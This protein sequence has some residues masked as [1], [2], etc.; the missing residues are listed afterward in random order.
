MRGGDDGMTAEEFMTSKLQSI[1]DKFADTVFCP[2]KGLF[3][4]GRE[5]KK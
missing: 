3:E 4:K 1:A 5:R 2:P